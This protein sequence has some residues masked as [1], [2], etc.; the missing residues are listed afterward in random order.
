M[1]RDTNTVGYGPFYTNPGGTG[2]FDTTWGYNL[3]NGFGFNAANADSTY[4][5]S[6]TVQPPAIYTLIIIKV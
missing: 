6:W 2:M 1:S 5:A 3:N 4:G